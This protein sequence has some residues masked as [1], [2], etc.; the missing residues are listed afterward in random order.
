MSSA[1]S[2]L[3]PR[4]A[5][6]SP[7]RSW[8]SST[9]QC[10]ACAGHVHLCRHRI[11]SHNE[12]D[13]E[14]R[15]DYATGTPNYI[16]TNIYDNAPDNSVGTPELAAAPSLTAYQTYT[17]EWFTNQVIWFVNGQQVRTETTN[18]PQGAM[19]VILDL[20]GYDG[21]YASLPPASSGPGTTYTADVE[22]VT[23]SR[24]RASRPAHDLPLQR[25][26]RRWK[27]LPLAKSWFRP[28]ARCGRSSGLAAAPSIVAN[29]ATQV[30]PGPCVSLPERSTMA[31]PCE[32]FGYRL[33][34]QSWWTKY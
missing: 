7:S 13:F 34:M 12:I 17:I 9:P 21:T 33:I 30:M 31:G 23:V 27:R 22:S 5:L 14:A 29:L 8:P 24:S 26:S 18:V 15:T 19:P 20:W 32:T 4:Q 10:P 1:P 11:K 3:S 6:A 16:Q 2:P 28:R 25:G